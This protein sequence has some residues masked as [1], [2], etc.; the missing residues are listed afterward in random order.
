MT[1]IEMNDKSDSY[2]GANVANRK[3]TSQLKIEG[4]KKNVAYVSVR[5]VSL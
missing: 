3:T 1:E 4:G 2:R 5:D